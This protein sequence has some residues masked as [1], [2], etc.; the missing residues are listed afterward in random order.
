[1]RFHYA[2]PFRCRLG[3]VC[4][5][6]VLIVTTS[7]SNQAT[8]QDP[9]TPETPASDAPSE[10]PAEPSNTD[11][12]EVSDPDAQDNKDSDTAEL[13]ADDRG[14]KDPK[15]LEAFVDGIMAVQFK[16]KHIAGAT[17]AFVVDNKPFFSKGYGD[18]DVDAGKPVDPDTTMFRVGSVSKLFTWLAVMRLVE[19]E[20]LDLD[21]D[22]NEYLT[23]FKV[24]DTFEEPVTLRH[25]L[26]HTPGFEDHV[27]GLFGRGA[28]DV[29][30]LGELLAD[31]MPA[32]VRAPG[33]LASYSNHGTALAGYIVQE[34]SK[35][36]WAEY[37]ETTILE[38]L[39]MQHTTVR[40]PPEEELPSDLSKGYSYSGGKFVEQGFEYVPAAPAGSMSASAGDMVKFMIAHL[41]NGKYGDTRIMSE[42]TARTMRDTLFTHDP[43]IEGMAYGF[44]R[45]RYGDEL[46]VEHG[47]DTLAF[48]SHF[49]MLPER[50]SGFFVSYNTT[51]AGA[52]RNT[53]LQALLDRYYPPKDPPPSKPTEDFATRSAQFPGTYGALRHA[54][55]SPAKLGALFSTLDVSADDDGLLIGGNDGRRYVEVEPSLFREV[56]GQRMIAFGH[57]EDAKD[58]KATQLFISGA[59]VAFERL[60]WF[61]TPNFSLLLI[62]ACVAVFASAVIGWPL[63][64]FIGRGDSQ[65]L[66]RTGGSKFASWIG[67]LTS[68]AALVAIGLAMIPLGN[69]NE[70]GYGIPPL[71]HGL[72]L[73]T[74]AIAVL[75][76][77]VFLCWIVAWAKSYWRFSARLHYTAVLAASLAFVWFLYQWNLLGYIA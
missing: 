5:I 55:T 48:H 44:M 25:L 42:E 77:G 10:A 11:E 38:P 63:A 1:M 70:I 23:E 76:L 34:V 37:I 61:E 15:E 72:L 43:R 29:R 46:I 35:M 4:A 39:E 2:E 31:E 14:P 33:K 27:I 17:I 47:G 41:Q 59:P 24:P 73:A 45:M 54:Y 28:D 30:P 40:Q 26:T 75:T 20:K 32:R 64:S 49:V 60:E 22:V 36:P 56:A 58:D 9:A 19:E 53:L 18:A 21:T 57:D 8:A 67:W 52:A 50:N 6:V 69:P 3:L 68:L 7:S 65:T 74:P 62:A 16:D 12:T 66:S 51:T 71:F 13:P